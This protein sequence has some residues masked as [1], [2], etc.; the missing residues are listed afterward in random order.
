MKNTPNSHLPPREITRKPNVIWVAQASPALSTPWCVNLNVISLCVPPLFEPWT[1]LEHTTA[2]TAF[3]S[4][5]YY[6]F[7]I[8][9]SNIWRR[10]IFPLALVAGPKPFSPS[11][12]SNPASLNPKS[13]QCITLTAQGCHPLPK[14][15]PSIHS[16]P[17]DD[18][19]ASSP[20]KSLPI[21]TCDGPCFQSLRQ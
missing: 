4:E 19:L 8:L 7:L 12:P 2:S 17:R 1:P 20:L 10:Y 21:F 5:G 16:A 18:V 13:S 3:P 9:G 11:L 6:F 14:A 15:V